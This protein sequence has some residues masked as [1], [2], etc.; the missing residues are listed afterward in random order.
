VRTKPRNG[1][2]ASFH[3]APDPLDSKFKSYYSYS[4]VGRSEVAVVSLGGLFTL[5]QRSS[6]SATPQPPLQVGLLARESTG[7]VATHPC[8]RSQLSDMCANK[9]KSPNQLFLCVWGVCGVCGVC[10]VLTGVCCV[11]SKEMP[12]VVPSPPP[13]VLLIGST[14]K[15]T[16]DR[17]LL[18]WQKATEGTRGR[19]VPL[20]ET[21]PRRTH[22]FK[23]KFESHKQS[24]SAPAAQRATT[25]TPP[26]APR[27]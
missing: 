18:A 2:V 19:S 13:M 27:T 7:F 26:T 1:V 22:P 14:I 25:H 15:P 21:P 12:P 4:V 11:R 8:T 23:K 20:S 6:S 3:P 24:P 5:R 10:G 9:Q 16:S 17:A